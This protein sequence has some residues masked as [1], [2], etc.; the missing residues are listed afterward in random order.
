[1]IVVT[2]PSPRCSR[3]LATNALA[4]NQTPNTV[5][6]ATNNTVA[7]AAGRLAAMARNPAPS[8]LS[9]DLTDPPDRPE[10]GVWESSASGTR[11][12]SATTK[13]TAKVV[14]GS[15]K[16]QAMPQTLTPLLPSP[17][18]LTRWR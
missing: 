13:P 15:A 5:T 17:V 7:A 6:L 10:V 11:I 4:T 14:A 12:S 2:P 8:I 18:R 9:C 16:A 1:M 3:S